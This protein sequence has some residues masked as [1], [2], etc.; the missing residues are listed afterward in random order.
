MDAHIQKRPDQCSESRR[1]KWR[2]EWNGK[3]HVFNSTSYCG[4]VNSGLV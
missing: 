1:T 4:R 2:N 3:H